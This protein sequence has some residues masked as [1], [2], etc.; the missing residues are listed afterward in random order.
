MLAH[1][2]EFL[3][4]SFFIAARRIHVVFCCCGFAGACCLP[5]DYFRWSFT[6]LPSLA[7]SRTPDL[8]LIHLHVLFLVILRDLDI[9]DFGFLILVFG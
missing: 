8:W 1:P 6:R 4:Q 9:Y 7:S 2:G 5:V 3:S